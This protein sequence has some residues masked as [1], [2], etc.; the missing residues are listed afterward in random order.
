MCW[1]ALLKLWNN[2]QCLEFKTEELILEIAV[3]RADKQFFKRRDVAV[4]QAQCTGIV[5]SLRFRREGKRRGYYSTV[6]TRRKRSEEDY[7]PS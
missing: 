3:F 1:V 5:L 7:F 6:K 2:V 4:V